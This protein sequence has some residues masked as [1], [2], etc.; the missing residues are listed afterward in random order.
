M[1][2]LHFNLENKTLII[3]ITSI[4]LGIN[5][6]STFKN[7][8]LYMDLGD[9]PSPKFNPRLILIKNV[10]CCF[11]LILFN[12]QSKY[13]L[14][15]IK[16]EK[17][18]VQTKVDDI[19][20]IKEKEIITKIGFLD[21]I[22][23]SHRLMTK[24]EKILFLFKN[25]FVIFIIYLI[26]E[27]YFIFANNHVMDRIV[28]AMRNLSLFLSL[29]I[30]Y[31]ILFRK[32]YAFYRHQVIPLIINIVF[33]LFLI[34]YNA[35]YIDRFWKVFNTKSL[36]FYFILFGLIGLEL[37]LIKYLNDKQFLSIFFILGI[38][39]LIGTVIFTILNIYYNKKQF[40]KLID[41]LI[42]FEYEDIYEDFPLSYYIIYILSL[43]IVQYLKT[44][45][46]SE[47]SETHY[48][49]SLMITDICFFIFYSI[50][51]FGLQKFNLNYI[52]SFI[53]NIL[54]SSF[55]IFLILLICEI[56]D[57]D[58]FDFNKYIRKSIKKRQL[59]ELLNSE[60]N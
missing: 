20:I 40:F 10:I 32:C 25:L 3:F 15:E 56:I 35:I 39:G 41:N 31:P 6:R 14:S 30:F 11:F 13:N 45:T 7:V 17:K 34:L 24:K 33:S 38:K 2:S 23:R 12:I 58:C 59:S 28:C 42:K 29:I 8:D 60:I 44:Y 4:A 1:G 27:S 5:F 49:C 47:L 46:I 53:L 43:I 22:Y 54:I 21:L 18:M 55:G 26:E 48:S 16:N 50:E 36:I 9:Y 51:R 19:I 57:L 52:P 37:I